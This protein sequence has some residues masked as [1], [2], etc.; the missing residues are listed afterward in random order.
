[1]FRLGRLPDPWQPPDWN[2]VHD[3]KTFGNR[4]DDPSGYYR[5]LYASTQR[6]S[7]FI[8]TL[9]RFR[10]DLSLMGELAEI[11]G[12]NDFVAV[13]SVPR[14][15]LEVRC[16]GAANLAGRFA[17]IYAS[18]WV[19]F[20]RTNLADDALQLGLN[21]IDVAVLQQASPRIITQKASRSVY[22][23]GLQGIFYRSR[24]GHDLENWA[25]FE[26]FQLSDKA[27]QSRLLSDD[28]DLLNA[29]ERLGLRLL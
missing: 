18:Q 20:L 13:G 8:E 26:P 9:A 6:V 4:F 17:N 10:P 2:W 23:R 3:D 5:V 1:M 27:S 22:E 12:E 21:D 29:L 15:W 16:M 28:P 19:S 7:C 24:Y 11:E 14:E 25:A